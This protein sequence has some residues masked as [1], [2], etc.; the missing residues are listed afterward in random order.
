MQCAC[1]GGSL[2]TLTCQ[3]LCLAHQMFIKPRLFLLLVGC[4]DVLCCCDDSLLPISV[5]QDVLAIVIFVLLCSTYYW[6]FSAFT[7]FCFCLCF[8]MFFML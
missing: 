4:H 5:Y 3:R 2:D 1:V 7:A 8:L 6:V